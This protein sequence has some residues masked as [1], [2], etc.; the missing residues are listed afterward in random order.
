MF[1]IVTGK[2]ICSVAAA[3]GT[4]IC[5]AVYTRQHIHHIQVK[6]LQFIFVLKFYALIITVTLPCE[7]F[8]FFLQYKVNRHIDCGAVQFFA[9]V[10]SS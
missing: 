2:F 7:L 5:A 10:G 6:L 8:L 9:A 1:A 4:Q 3:E